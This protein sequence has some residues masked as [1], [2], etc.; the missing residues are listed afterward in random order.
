[1][2]VRRTG[3][4]KVLVL[5]DTWLIPPLERELRARKLIPVYPHIVARKIETASGPKWERKLI[6]IVPSL[7]D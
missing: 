3:I 6:G 5:A 4:L 7:Q 2:A 1:M